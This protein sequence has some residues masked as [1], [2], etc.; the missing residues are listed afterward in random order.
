[1]PIRAK[2]EIYSALRANEL[3]GAA[4]IIAAGFLVALDTWLHLAA[5]ELRRRGGPTAVRIASEAEERQ[6]DEALA[7]LR[8]LSMKR[9]IELVD[10]IATSAVGRAA[11]AGASA[12]RQTA[13]RKQWRQDA[14]AFRVSAEAL[15][16]RLRA[17]LGVPFPRTLK[18]WNAFEQA[19]IARLRA[20]GLS[21]GEITKLTR[22]GVQAAGTVEGRKRAERERVRGSARRARARRA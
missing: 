6:R 7:L 20:S 2:R 17:P 19:L 11:L 16:Q 18:E 22:P 10:D 15:E 14:E 8:G 5:P 3:Q 13:L 9:L 21:Y 4:E 12:E 1:M